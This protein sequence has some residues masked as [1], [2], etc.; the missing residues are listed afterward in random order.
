MTAAP[1]RDRAVVIT[2]AAGGIG[3]ALAHRFARA[4]ARLGLLDCDLV[5]LDA[6][7]GELGE[8]ALAVATDVTSWEQCRS[9][10]SLLHQKLGG[11]DVLINNAGITH[12]SPFADTDPAVL[13]RVMDVNFF[14][15]VHCTRAALDAGFARGG[16][17]VVVS[18][19]AGFAPLAGRSGYAASKHALHGLFESVRAELRPRGVDVMLVCPG[20][21]DTPIEAHALGA[22]GE[23][24]RQ[25]RASV[26]RL[27]SPDDV[28]EAIY[29][30]VR[31]G[32][33]LI[34]LTPVGKLSRLLSRFAPSL[35]ERLMAR[36]MLPPQP[37][38]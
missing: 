15:A 11:I 30:G 32:R 34:V 4:G 6:L 25:A 10:V 38:R 18:S 23:R 26:G 28:A 16:M 31:R 5:P 7:A 14:G 35:Y 17:V 33:R 36:R 19:V 22:D 20:F 27:A 3:R 9:A 12:V 37:E 8:R 29:R 24:P 13:R 2:G 1:L 21:T